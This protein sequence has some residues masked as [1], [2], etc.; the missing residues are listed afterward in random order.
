M[1]EDK[2]TQTDWVDSNVND[3]NVVVVD[4]FA[5]PHKI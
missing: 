3:K 1:H 5:T 4:S 2:L